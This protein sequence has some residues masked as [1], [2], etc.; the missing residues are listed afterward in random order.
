MLESTFTSVIAAPG[1]D[2]VWISVRNSADHWFALVSNIIFFVLGAGLTLGLEWWRNRRDHRKRLLITAMAWSTAAEQLRIVLDR[3]REHLRQHHETYCTSASELYWIPEIALSFYRE[4]PELRVVHRVRWIDEIVHQFNYNL[5]A[6]RHGAAIA[7]GDEYYDKLR[8]AYHEVRSHLA[9]Y[10][11][12]HGMKDV[13]V[14]EELPIARQ[15][16]SEVPGKTN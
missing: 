11:D 15:G 2:T 7:F 4:C 3:M 12:K 9:M 16:S 1:Q 10:L 8:D 13:S 14:P 6:G 5:H